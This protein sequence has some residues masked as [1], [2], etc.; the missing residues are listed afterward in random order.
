MKANTQQMITTEIQVAHRHTET[1]WG[2]S[3]TYT[4][5]NTTPMVDHA[6]MTKTRSVVLNSVLSLLALGCELL[7]FLSYIL[8]ECPYV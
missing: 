1:F 2:I 3:S 7:I 4:N 6:P 8:G 5:A